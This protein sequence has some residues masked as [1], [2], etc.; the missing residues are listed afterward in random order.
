MAECRDSKE[1][2]QSVRACSPPSAM[3][4]SSRHLYRLSRCLQALAG[5]LLEVDPREVCQGD[6]EAVG[7]CSGLWRRDWRMTVLEKDRER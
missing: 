4:L 2:I 1:T 6:F 3:V 5:R 7:P